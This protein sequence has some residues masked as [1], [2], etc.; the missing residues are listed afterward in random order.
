MLFI[1]G[2][3]HL[4]DRYGRTPIQILPSITRDKYTFTW[5]PR[6]TEIKTSEGLL[7]LEGIW[8]PFLVEKEVYVTNGE[9]INIIN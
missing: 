1:G 8:W 7:A 9:K 3:I 4:Y 5:K 6:V 2:V